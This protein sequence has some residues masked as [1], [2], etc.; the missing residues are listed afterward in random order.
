ML[1]ITLYALKL[2]FSIEFVK[3]SI[4]LSH[5]FI[6]KD[7]KLNHV[8]VDKEAKVSIIKELEG[9]AERPLVVKQE[10]VV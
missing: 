2:T 8:V 6:S 5:A 1:S 10:D 7:S 9:S 4:I 3:N